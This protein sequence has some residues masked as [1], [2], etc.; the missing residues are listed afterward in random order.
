M[1]SCKADYI[2][3]TDDD[4]FVDTFHLPRYILFHQPGLIQMCN[5]RFLTQLPGAADR[6][7][8]CQVLDRKPERD[9]D[10]KWFVTQEE[11]SGKSYPPYCAGWAYVTTTPTIESILSA[12]YNVDP[13]WI[14]DLHVTGLIPA[15][16][17]SGHIP[18]YDWSY[19]FLNQHSHYR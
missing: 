7:F 9:P 6:W 19:C 10:N 17:K 13:L 3:K 18:L 8:L 11:Y 14:D 15:S 12:S 5:H 16:M 1:K 2:L 4:I